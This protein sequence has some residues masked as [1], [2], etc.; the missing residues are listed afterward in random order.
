MKNITETTSISFELLIE[1][2]KSGKVRIPHFQRKL[3]WNLENTALFIDS[4]FRNTPLGT[5]ITWE[6]DERLSSER[7]I[8]GMDLS[9][10]KGDY[11]YILDGQQRSTTM[12]SALQGLT[13]Q[14]MDFKKLYV[15]LDIN[16]EEF[17]FEKIT[18]VVQKENVAENLYPFYK[19][20]GEEYDD[21]ILDI[22]SRIHRRNAQKFVKKLNKTELSGVKIITDSVDVAIAHFQAINT[23]GKQLSLAEIIGCLLF[24]EDKKWFFHEKTERL[25]EEAELK[26]FKIDKNFQLK[27]T[28]Y[29]LYGRID[30][31]TQK[32]IRKNDIINNWENIKASLFRAI[33]FLKNNYNLARKSDIFSDNLLY[34][35]TYFFYKNNLKNPSLSQK[36]KMEKHIMYYG[37]TQR[38]EANTVANLMQDA[39]VF[40]KIILNK[41]IEE[42]VKLIRFGTEDEKEEILQLGYFNQLKNM[43]TFPKFIANVLAMNEPISFA[44]GQKVKYSG[45]QQINQMHR[46]HIFPESIYGKASNNVFNIMLLDAQT[47][48]AIGNS[49][50]DSYMT[51]YYGEDFIN[52]YRTNSDFKKIMDSQFIEVDALTAIKNNDIES[53]KRHRMIS[54][55]NFMKSYFE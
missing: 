30:I 49:K 32:S 23:G 46:H 34:M 16:P 43:P 21:D 6:S 11:S 9:N 54:I 7:A 42:D 25:E 5:I 36:V 1:N 29:C 51:E 33:E 15:N 10:N 24:D 19:L 26:G 28:S 14:G 22:E 3:V 35:L 8:G 2:I 41:S 40:D 39:K 48:Q 55:F 20:W 37:T 52:K 38:Y 50:P 18:Y 45:E 31:V 53:F 27:L 44:T 47:N 17:T 13:V 12:F 4:I